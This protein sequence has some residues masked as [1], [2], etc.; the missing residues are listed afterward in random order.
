MSSPLVTVGFKAHLGWLAAVAVRANTDEPWPLAAERLDLFADQPREIREPYH[1]AGGWDGLTRVDPPADPAALIEKSLALQATRTEA[2]LLRY[3]VE[4]SEAGLQWRHAVVL[5]GRGI[6]HDLQNT[7]S[8]HAHI[9]IAEGEAVRQATRTALS[10]MRLPWVEQDEK[11]ALAGA[12]GLLK[13]SKEE[14]ENRLEQRR[15]EQARSWTKE[16]QTIAAAAWLAE[17]RSAV[18]D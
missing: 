6:V 17:R 5:I 11:S 9:H 18:P 12:S 14:L 10:H 13:I 2:R 15:P 4:L 8:S 7:L 3:H 16:H 1:V